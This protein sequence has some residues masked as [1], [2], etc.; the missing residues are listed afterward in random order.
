MLIDRYELS[1]RVATGGMGTIYQ[2]HDHRLG[3][4]VAVKLLKDE[5]AQDPRF[6]ER[7][8]REA[9]AAAALSH[10]CIAAVFDYGE[11]DGT[12]FIVMELAEGRDLARLLREEGPLS[13]DRAVRVATQICEALGHAHAAGVVHR[14][15][16]P[17]NVI[18]GDDDRVKVTDFGI[19]RA[20]GDSTLT[21]TG[22]VLGTAHYIS[23]EQAEGSKVGPASD[24]YSLGIVLYEMLTGS[25][26]FTGDSPVSVAMRHV[27]DDVPAPSALN[28]AVPPELDAVVARAT[29][30]PPGDR[31]HDAVGMATALGAGLEPTGETVTREVAAEPAQRTQLLPETRWDPYKLGRTVIVIM[32]GLAL[33]AA[34]LLAYRLVSADG[35]DR[36]RPRQRGGGAAAATD[37]PTPTPTP[38]AA[39]LVAYVM[40][41]LEGLNAK[42]VKKSLEEL[43]LHVEEIPVDDA[44]EKDTIIDFEPAIGTEVL[45]G[46]T[47]TLTISSGHE[48][49]EDD[50]D[51]EHVPP[52][53]EK[54][55]D[56]D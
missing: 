51:E 34:A 56:D 43:G 30:R 29:A 21:A 19:A 31:W 54:K 50:E 39:S 3:R 9:R 20:V 37:S 13:P 33:L 44:A 49:E 10:P 40:E 14:D 47:I 48:P 55:E 36:D 4:R 28:P 2:A 27:T 1:E 24:I 8:R 42:E 12:H 15:V 53:Q 41:D 17:A 22:S 5:L 26:P 23:P 7:F 32:A 46:E 16:K 45:V 35:D 52:G 38:T 6:V 25:M 18:V 11:Q